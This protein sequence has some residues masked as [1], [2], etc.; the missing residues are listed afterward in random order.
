MT[1]VA[2]STVEPVPDEELTFIIPS[3]EGG[4]NLPKFISQARETFK[5]DVL[6]TNGSRKESLITLRLQRRLTMTNVLDELKNMS[7]VEEVWAKQIRADAMS[8]MGVLVVLSP[9][10]DVAE[11]GVGGPTP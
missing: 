7:G 1:K 6:K 8:R 10:S 9:G 4:T 11:R 3:T 5:A 2:E